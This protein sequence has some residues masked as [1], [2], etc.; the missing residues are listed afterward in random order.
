MRSLTFMLLP[1]AAA[2]APPA[3]ASELI[4]GPVCALVEGLPG[5]KA[6]VRKV[7]SVSAILAV[8]DNPKTPPKQ[9]ARRYDQLDGLIR[10]A[11]EEATR[12][13]HAKPQHEWRSRDKTRARRY[14]EKFVLG[15][16][17]ILQIGSVGFEPR[18]GLRAALQYAACRAGRPEEAIRWG[19]RASRPEEAPARAFAALL[20][21]DAGRTD[22]ARE[23][24]ATIRGPSFL[25][26]WIRAELHDDPDERRRQRASAR[27][28]VT[29][30]AQQ[31][32]VTAQAE[33][34]SREGVGARPR[35]GGE[36]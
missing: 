16:R 15:I 20:L 1:F 17:P 9:M 33:R 21:Q 25:T 23:L 6:P 8:V 26:A 12:V 28:R 10:R 32:A 34:A 24:L 27:R 29:T 5:P 36:R 22:E 2:M 30:S 18:P 3:A 35:S 31:D 4:R 7:R 11:L 19:R 13:F 14:L